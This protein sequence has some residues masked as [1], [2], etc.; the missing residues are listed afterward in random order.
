METWMTSLEDQ[1]EGKCFVIVIV[2]APTGSN[3]V[4]RSEARA[5]FL[6][7]GG[8]HAGHLKAPLTGSICCCWF[9]M[10]MLNLW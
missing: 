2:S 6:G 10:I 7:C 3:A 1:P 4:Q 9:V 5:R 8:A